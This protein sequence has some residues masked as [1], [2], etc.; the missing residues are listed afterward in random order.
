MHG[1]TA[2]HTQGEAC[3]TTSH[4][5]IKADAALWALCVAPPKGPVLA[6]PADE[7]EPEL[8]PAYVVEMR[9]CPACG[10]TL[11]VERR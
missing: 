11:C 5:S 2:Q 6:I 10:S 9:N 3:T 7:D 4:E 1:G 8:Y